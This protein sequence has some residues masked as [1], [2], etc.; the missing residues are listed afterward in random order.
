M[1]LVM[2]ILRL[3]HVIAGVLWVGG[4]VYTFRFVEP[5]AKALG[6]QAEPFMGYMV[7]IKKMPQYFIA[8]SSLTV[9]AG[10]AL[11]WI[12]AAGDPIGWITRDATGLTFAIGGVA[13]WTAFIIGMV[14]IKPAMDELGAAGQAIKSADG[15]PTPE[16]MGRMHA[17]EARLDRLGK[18]DLALLGVA[19]VT[20][21]IA[22]Y[23]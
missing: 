17:V 4:A 9:L 20:M 15:P 5:A 14:G 13:A 23:L 18:I 12:D 7:G 16:M 22:R 6:P 8:A 10:T 11:F 21:A 1:D 2:I 19:I 3:I